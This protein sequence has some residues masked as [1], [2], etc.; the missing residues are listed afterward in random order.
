M[1]NFYDQQIKAL[2]AL[3]CTTKRSREDRSLF[4][5]TNSPSEGIYIMLNKINLYNRE[6]KKQPDCSGC[7]TFHNT[8]QKYSA[9]SYVNYSVAPDAA[10]IASILFKVASALSIILS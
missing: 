3:P 5:I 2:E 10:S 7:P 9:F 8:S 6:T 4:N 1:S